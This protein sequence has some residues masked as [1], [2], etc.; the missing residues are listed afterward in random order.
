MAPLFPKKSFFRGLIFGL[1][2]VVLAAWVFSHQAVPILMYH[3]IEPSREFRAD[4]VSPERLREHLAA[5][6]RQGYDFIT[7]N[8]VVR[9]IRQGR[10]PRRKAVVVTIDDG[11]DDVYDYALPVLKEF[12]VPAILFISPGLLGEDGFLTK[13]QVI[14]LQKA[15]MIL[16][17]HGMTQAYLPDLNEEQRRYEIFESKRRLEAMFGQR[18][19]FFAYPV[20]GFDEGIKGLVREAGYQGAVTTNRGRDRANRDPFEL[21]RIRLSDK[22]R[23]G[24]DLWAKLSGY[25][26]VFRRLKPAN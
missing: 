25:Y 11:Y 8:D 16:G 18:I 15:G 2:L 4:K 6:A 12:R 13:D 23:H 26:N 21:N 3:H 10:R 19:D 9:D 24:Y 14:A 20:G 5:M 7:L 1:P 22:D 17:S